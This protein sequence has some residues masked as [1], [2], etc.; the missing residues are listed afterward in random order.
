MKKTVSSLI[1]LPLLIVL[2]G[3]CQAV[4]GIEVLDETTGADSSIPTVDAGPEAQP[5]V[6]T[7]SSDSPAAE[8]APEAASDVL[9][10]AEAAPPQETGPVTC[11]PK[12]SSSG[13][14]RPPCKPAVAD[15]PSLANPLVFAVQ[16]MRGGMDADTPDDWQSLG[17]DLDCLNTG[18]SGDP[19]SCIR[20]PGAGGKKVQDGLL[21]R[22]NS[23]GN[24]IGGL[25]RS[26]SASLDK[27][28]EG[29]HNVG[30]YVG[31]QGILFVIEGYNGLA[32]DPKVSVTML[33]SAGT[34][35]DAGNH[36]DP[37]WL[38]S[39]KW[40]I[41]SSC[42]AQFS[43][44]PKFRDNDAYV[45]G[46]VVV[47]RMPAGI[48]FTFRGETSNVV[49][50]LNENITL[51][52][53]TPELT[54]LTD[55]VIAGVWPKVSATEALST[56]ANGLGVCP[57]HFAWPTLQTSIRE[58]ID[59]RLD[60]VPDPKNDCQA[61]SIGLA[62]EALPALRGPKVTPPEPQPNPCVQ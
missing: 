18:E 35:D 24:N 56:F 62:F 4:L 13:L 15:G 55:G 61:I 2:C 60:A 8:A 54:A 23:F 52:R 19:A 26:M 31:L 17:L 29:A 6:S 50:S 32:D 28:I 57:D 49:M 39:D 5:D 51:M 48:P 27:N 12:C 36:K 46:H 53:L 21:G 44:E 10:E 37:G 38:G 30:L 20:E 45:A 22:D 59:I 25:V 7:E 58:S 3:G 47:A 40:S 16:S 33:V 9:I 43:D 42:L 11:D 41:D 1:P 34:V 14:V